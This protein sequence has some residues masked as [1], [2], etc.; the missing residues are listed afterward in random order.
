MGFNVTEESEYM[1]L[2]CSL[3]CILQNCL[4][5]FI[6]DV[7]LTVNI[8]AAFVL[9]LF[10]AAVIKNVSEYSHLVMITHLGMTTNIVEFKITFLDD[11]QHI[12]AL[13][14]SKN[15]YCLES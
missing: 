11:D 5:F 1:W 14:I 8:L 3:I 9:H 6:S 15:P 4:F 13:R 12:R 7:H 10:F 2:Y